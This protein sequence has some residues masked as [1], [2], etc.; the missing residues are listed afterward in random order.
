MSRRGTIKQDPGGTWSLV[1][2]TAPTGTVRRQIRRRGFRT[3]REAQAELNRLLH[4]LDEGAF[5]KPDRITVA[6]YLQAWL[7]GLEVA[8]HRP[9]TVESYRR[10]LRLHVIPTL[11]PARLQALGPLDLDRL[12]ARLLQ[13]GRADDSGGLSPRTVRYLHTILGRALADAER[14]GLVIRNVSKA[15]TPPSAKAARAPEMAFW[16]PDELH[17][18]LAFMADDALFP[19][20]RLA[21]MTGMRRGEVC[22]L[23]WEDVKLDER[24][25]LVRRQLNVLNGGL[26]FQDHLKTDH[27][28]RTVGLDVKTVAVLRAHRAKQA[29]GR[30]LA[31]SLWHDHGLVFTGPFGDPLHPHQ[32]SRMFSRRA[33]QAGLRPI[34]FHDLRHSHC[35]HLI[36]AGRNVKAIS[37]RLGHASVSFTLDRYG[38][39][40]PDDD[41]EAAEAVAAMIDKAAGQS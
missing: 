12:Y 35:A 41:S 3:K 38:H 18:F 10:N 15:A 11:G 30:L 9:S 5:V 1:V 21:S 19:L 2:D 4:S 36:A 24:R 20:V 40:L 32:V 39:L 26:L 23:L 31:G 37:R 25:L 17:R 33:Q 14:K 34:R 29:E 6:E 8:G 13:D 28:R 7:D 27:G 16:N 22:G